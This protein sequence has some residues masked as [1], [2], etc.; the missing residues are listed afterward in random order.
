LIL[1]SIVTFIWILSIAFLIS[2]EVNIYSKASILTMTAGLL[3]FLYIY[4]KKEKKNPVIVQAEQM[5]ENLKDKRKDLKI[6][7]SQANTK[8]ERVKL[9]GQNGIVPKRTWNP[10]QLETL[11]CVVDRNNKVLEAVEYQ[12]VKL[13][14][15]FIQQEASIANNTA[16]NLIKKYIS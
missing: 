7:L 11:K 15:Y 5:L 2:R 9:S 8:L 13:E 1:L 10:E 6:F 14:H 3:I 12:I 16:T 4:N